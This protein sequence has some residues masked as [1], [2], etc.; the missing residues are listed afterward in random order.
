VLAALERLAVSYRSGDMSKKQ[1]MLVAVDDSDASRRALSY[2][3]SFLAG[4]ADVSVRLFH[5][6]PHL[7][8]ETLE[9]GGTTDPAKERAFLAEKKAQFIAEAE[10][11]AQPAVDHARR[12][13]R[14]AGVP[15]HA[16]ETQFYPSVATADV[17]D[18]ILDVARQGGFGTV[19]VGRNSW[20]R[21]KEAFRH[22]ICHELIKKGRGVSVWVVE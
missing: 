6:L 12:T 5:V 8:P 1:K 3:A 16:I 20:P 7:P 9:W 15:E 18:D 14:E 17:V 11:T 2:V 4:C 19:V 10:K 13:L 22:H 21:L